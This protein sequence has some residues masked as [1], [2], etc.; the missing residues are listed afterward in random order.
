MGNAAWL[1][2]PR[3]SLWYPTCQVFETNLEI[4]QNLI[5]DWKWLGEMNDKKSGGIGTGYDGPT[6][7]S[8]YW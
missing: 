5:V 4:Y 2:L 1:S 3:L 7:S 6:K 8:I